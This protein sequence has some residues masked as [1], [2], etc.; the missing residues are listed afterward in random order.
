ME[1]SS[2]TPFIVDGSENKTFFLFF[3]H[4]Y[5]NNFVGGQQRDEHRING[6]TT[7]SSLR[8]VTRG[9]YGEEQLWLEA[10]NLAKFP[11]LNQQV[12]SVSAVQIQTQF[13]RFF[14]FFFRSF[15]Q[16]ASMHVTMKQ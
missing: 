1:F 8:E 11:M 7:E 16:N 14:F 5:N 13:S 15:W 12:A 3:K 2:G 4:K 6:A 9:F 10:Q